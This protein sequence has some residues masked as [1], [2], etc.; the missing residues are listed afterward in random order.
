MTKKRKLFLAATAFVVSALMLTGTFAWTQMTNKVNEFIG[1]KGGGI[2]I[3]DDF[4]PATGKKDVFVESHSAAPVFVRVKLN[5]AMSLTDNTW[6]PLVPGDWTAHT[7]ELT[8]GNCGNANAAGDLFHDYFD[9]EMGGWK[10]YMPSDGS[11]QVVQ[12]TANYVGTETGIAKTPEAGFITAADYLALNAQ[13]QEDFVG[14]IYD[15][16]GYAYWSQPLYDGDVTGLLLH[17][18]F[19]KALLK[20]T[21]Y[22]YA[23][24]VIA[25]AVDEADIPMWT[26]GVAS[27]DGT[28]TT[29]PAATMDG[30]DVINR[31]L[32]LV[33]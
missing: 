26:Q 15:T 10:W 5:E 13:E 29:Y 28:G 8:P 23:I 9:W 16:D 7:Y 22:Y 19:T 30:K 24:D 32:E 20:N 25:E 2:T 4:D 33:V 6:R 12:D 17:R 14:W 11:Q 1:T 21:E 27:V 31:I 3:R 18:V